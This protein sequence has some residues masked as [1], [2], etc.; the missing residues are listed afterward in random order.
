[1]IFL[2]LI[3][4]FADSNVVEMNAFMTN[5]RKAIAEQKQK[6]QEN[7]DQLIS[8]FDPNST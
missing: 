1:M 2:G 4:T 5:I 6:E 7:I 8:E 3:S